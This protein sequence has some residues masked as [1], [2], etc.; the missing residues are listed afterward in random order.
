MMPAFHPSYTLWKSLWASHIPTA[1]TTG[2]M[3]SHALKS[4]H[5]HRKGLITDVSGPQRN[6]CPG[7]LTSVQTTE[8][9]LRTE[10]SLVSAVNDGL[11]LDLG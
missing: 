7:A 9:Y 6:A 10:Q 3:S 4:N 5:R 11:G 2:Y 8:R 1:S